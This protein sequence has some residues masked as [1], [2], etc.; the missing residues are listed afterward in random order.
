LLAHPARRAD[1]HA[2]LAPQ[3]HLP[4]AVESAVH[5]VFAPLHGDDTDE[6]QP[7]ALV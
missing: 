3:T 5:A 2:A 6:V 4:H 1:P 7:D